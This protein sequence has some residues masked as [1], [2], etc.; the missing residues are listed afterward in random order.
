MGKHVYSIVEKTSDKAKRNEGK[1]GNL[2][3]EEASCP[4]VTQNFQWRWWRSAMVWIRNC[5]FH[6][7]LKAGG[8]FEDNWSKKSHSE[9]FQKGFVLEDYR[10]LDTNGSSERWQPTLNVDACSTVCGIFKGNEC[11]QVIRP[12]PRSFFWDGCGAYILLKKLVAVWE[13][14]GAWPV[15]WAAIV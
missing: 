9:L 11:S 5:C 12:F 1:K 7:C 4:R 3:F 8:G 13:S 10:Y 6:F 2:V 14:I 15:T